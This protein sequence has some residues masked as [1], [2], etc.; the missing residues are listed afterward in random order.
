MKKLPIFNAII[1]DETDGIFT[2]SLVSEPATEKNWLCFNKDNQIT[3]K[4]TIADEEQHLLAGVVMVADTPIYRRDGEYE[5]YIQFSKETIKV[6]AEKMLSDKT[7]N[8]IDLQHDGF[9]LEDGVVSL[10]ELFIKDSEKGIN[11]T[12]VDV[13]EGSLLAMYKVNDEELWE[14]AKDGS[15]NGFSLEGNFTIIEPEKFEKQN[16]KHN[17][18]KKM[19]SKIKEMLKSILSDFAKV[20]TD[21]GELV[22][23]GELAEGIEV[24]DENGDAVADGEYATEDSVIIVKDS[25]V[26][27]INA[28]EAEEPKE[29]EVAEETA[30]E[31]VEAEDEVPTVEEIAEEPKEDE[32]PQEDPAIAQMREEISMLR[33]EIEMLKKEVANM[34]MQPMAE[35]VAEVFEKVVERD[36]KMSKAERIASYLR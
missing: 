1:A 35:P 15:L 3:E 22:Y 21:K 5:Y 16:N 17:N 34:G 25:K 12:Y 23:E 7:H 31:E 14:K 30:E 4:F 10:V 11:P 24:V 2:M 6:M 26:E 36:S 20:S 13:P 19:K 29:E 8:R 33:N 28:K 9:I 18:Y 27:A 32:A